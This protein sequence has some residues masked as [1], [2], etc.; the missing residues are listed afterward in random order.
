MST[1]THCC[2]KVLSENQKVA[3][4][5]KSGERQQKKVKAQAAD[6]NWSDLIGDRQAGAGQVTKKE[7]LTDFKKYFFLFVEK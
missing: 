2:V 5:T 4:Q 7:C 3:A 6:N 1:L